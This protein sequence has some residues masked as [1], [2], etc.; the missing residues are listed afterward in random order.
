MH[1]LVYTVV[2]L[3]V[4]SVCIWQRGPRPRGTPN[5]LR[6]SGVTGRGVTAGEER[7]GTPATV[8]LHIP[9]T[10]NVDHANHDNPTVLFR[11]NLVVLIS[12]IFSYFSIVCGY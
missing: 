2:F 8:P 5:G 1:V 7:G 3:R 11:I 6:V 4:L 10:G 9:R 12:R